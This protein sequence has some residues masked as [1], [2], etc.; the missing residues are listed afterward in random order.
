MISGSG[1]AAFFCHIAEINA[2]H[3]CNIFLAFLSLVVMAMILCIR[4]SLPVLRMNRIKHI[5]LTP[6]FSDNSSPSHI[7]SV[8]HKP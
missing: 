5:T 8:G 3:S 2:I 1:P 6:S 7:V 4:I